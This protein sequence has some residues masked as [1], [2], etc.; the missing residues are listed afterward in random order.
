MAKARSIN[1]LDVQA[2]TRENARIIARTRLDELFAWSKY[3]DDAFRIRELHDMRIA[4]KRL[5]Y[6]LEIFEDVLPEA[7]ASIIVEVTQIQ[8]ELGAL[9]DNDVSVALLRLCLGSEDGGTM[10]EGALAKAAQKDLQGKSLVNPELVA[11]V[12]DPKAVPNP[13]QRRSLEAL[14]RRLEQQRQ[15]NYNTFRTHWNMLQAHDFK[16]QVL[17]AISAW[18]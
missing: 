15:E 5:R 9:H 12:V 18:S 11:Y 17:D 13:E 7:V 4:A 3:V 6:T 10:Y 2:S 8:E 1:N 16:R 14:L